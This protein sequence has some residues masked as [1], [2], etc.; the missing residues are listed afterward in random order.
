MLTLYILFCHSTS[1]QYEYYFPI[2]FK[3]IPQPIIIQSVKDRQQT[4]LTYWPDGVIGY[5]FPNKFYASNGGQTVLTTGD[6]YNPVQS[7]QNIKLHTWQSF[8]Y[9]AFGST[10][11]YNNII[12][13][14]YH[15]E[16]W[17]NGYNQFV[18]KLGTATSIDG[19]NFYDTGLAVTSPYSGAVE[20][21]GGAII[22]NGE[23]FYLYFRDKL[24]NGE[25]INLAAARLEKNKILSCCNEWK[26]YYNGEFSQPGIG[27]LSS[28]L[29]ID[30]PVNAWFD[31]DK[32]DNVYYMTTTNTHNIYLV[33][34]KDGINWAE[35]KTI[36]VSE[37]ELFYPSLIMPFVYY[38][39]SKLGG[40]QR[41]NDARLLRI[42]VDS[43]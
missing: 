7:I 22:E 29:E 38:T 32:I 28:S 12:I 10:L 37:N 35:R 20:M 4:G 36:V 40:F 26:K 41:W 1:A 42:Y 6:F 17:P 43:Y 33:T 24:P 14:V 34:S 27:G 31:I 25:I 13:A 23:Y 16:K 9:M 8:D 39:E 15:A 3:D 30:N 18:S 2:I 5:I 19:I 11:E 21:G